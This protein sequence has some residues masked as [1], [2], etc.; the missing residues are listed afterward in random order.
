[1]FS[2]FLPSEIHKHLIAEIIALLIFFLWHCFNSRWIVGWGTKSYSGPSE[3][4]SFS[5]RDLS[6]RNKHDFFWFVVSARFLYI[7]FS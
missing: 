5:G 4:A 2:D 7:L 1:M 3:I 6:R